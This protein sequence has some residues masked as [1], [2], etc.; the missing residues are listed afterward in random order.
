MNAEEAL[1]SL[2]HTHSSP[3]HTHTPATQ[4]CCRRR[5]PCLGTTGQGFGVAAAAAVADAASYLL[6]LGCWRCCGCHC[7]LANQQSPAEPRARNE[8][9]SVFGLGTE[10]WRTKRK[11][12]QIASSRAGVQQMTLG[13][14]SRVR[15]RRQGC[16]HRGAIRGLLCAEFAVPGCDTGVHTAE[17]ARSAV[18]ER[19]VSVC[20][21]S[22]FALAW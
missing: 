1:Q 22:K 7:S 21:E 18:G 4:P 11:T 13:M 3:P 19:S 15:T 20:N 5:L 6:T 8:G 10:T 12:P 14:D 17:A 9:T 16:P 2:R